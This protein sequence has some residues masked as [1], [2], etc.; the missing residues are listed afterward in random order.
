M[1]PDKRRKDILQATARATVD[2]GQEREG[3]GQQSPKGLCGDQSFRQQ[4]RKD[5]AGVQQGLRQ[6]M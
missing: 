5:L 4:T 6:G 2:S 1:V 3:W